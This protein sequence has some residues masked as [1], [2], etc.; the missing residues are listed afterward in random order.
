MCTHRIPRDPPTPSLPSTG[1]EGEDTICVWKTVKV[2]TDQDCD[3]DQPRN[4]NWKLPC[5]VLSHQEPSRSHW[6]RG[7]SLSLTMPPPLFSLLI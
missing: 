6:D 7:A 2:K 1:G 5:P 4:W 3:Q